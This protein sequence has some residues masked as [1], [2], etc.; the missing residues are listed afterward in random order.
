V[1]E[2]LPR[3]S[4]L[5]FGEAAAGGAIPRKP[6]P[7]G[8]FEEAIIRDAI[9]R[10][11]AGDPSFAKALEK[12]K[13]HEK[14]APPPRAKPEPPTKP[15][16]GGKVGQ[17]LKSTTQ[18][19][20]EMEEAAAQ[21]TVT[22]ANKGGTGSKRKTPIKGGQRRDQPAKATA[23]KRPGGDESKVEPSKASKPPQTTEPAKPP[24]EVETT[25]PPVSTEPPE[26]TQPPQVTVP[27]TSGGT[28]TL[29]QGISNK[30]IKAGSGLPWTGKGEEP[31]WANPKSQKAYDHIES[32]HGPKLK[33]ENFRGRIGSTSDP[34]G[35]WYNAEDWVLAER[36]APKYP[37]RY[38]IDFGRP[39]GRVYQVDGTVVENVSRAFVQRNLDGTLNSAFPVT[40]NFVLRPMGGSTSGPTGGSTPPTK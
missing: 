39:V 9:G 1:V 40:N 31:K 26:P 13:V 32:T 28:P 34:Q 23:G 12:P 30:P 2:G 20:M 17:T 8:E 36:V 25:K 10:P 11:R 5:E 38:I 21:Q 24:V 6:L 37:G 18:R 33:P 15:Q 16:K 4:T 27:A 7:K 22:A 14:T 19:V 29:V 3:L 35:Q